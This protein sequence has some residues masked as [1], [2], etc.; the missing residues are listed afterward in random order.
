MQ[1]TLLI[2]FFLLI[3]IVSSC[4][5]IHAQNPVNW[6]GKELME[7][8]ELAEIIKNNPG[9]VTLIS[10]GPFTTIPGTINIGMVSENDKLDK[11]KVQLSTLKKDRQ[12]VIY[13][14]CC[15]FDKCP[16]VRPA[17]NVL[18]EMHF[19]NYYL[20]NLPNNLRINWIDKGYPAIKL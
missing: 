10:V 12:V 2:K 6:T 16:N 19:T 15:P 14:G 18:R 11:F 3:C 20:L 7:P 5:N 4:V 1:K 17:I 9:D 13:C 8:S